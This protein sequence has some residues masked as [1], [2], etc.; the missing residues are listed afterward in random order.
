MAGAFTAVDL[1]QLAAPDVV[2]TI[3]FEV[4]LAEML[5]DLQQRDP[6]FS[7]LLESDPA[8]KILQVAAYRETLIRQR[9]NE[10]AKGVMLAYAV[11]SDLDQIAANYNVARLVLDPGDPSAIPPVPPTFEDDASLRRRVQLSFEGFSTAGPVGAYI[12]HALGADPD[13]LD[14]SVESPDP[15]EVVVTVLS[16]QGDG[17]ADAGLIEAVDATLSADTVRPLTD[18]VTV[19]SATIVPYAV[20]AVLTLFP[21]PD[22]GVVLAQAQAALARYIATSQRLG[23]DITRSAIFAALHQPGVQNVDLIEPAADI[24]IDPD[25]ASFNTGVDVTIGGVDE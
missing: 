7:A 8:F 10:G 16:R 1:S 23:R 14:V 3:D 2:E 17:T 22:G 4:I 18:Q 6:T 12:F 24:V 5:A 19:Q 15:G 9:V 11:G 13:V 25:E 20:E 21:G